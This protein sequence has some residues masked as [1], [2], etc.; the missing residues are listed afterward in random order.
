MPTVVPWAYRDRP[1]PLHFHAKA[2]GTPVRE[3]HLIHVGLSVSRTARHR[4]DTGAA[5][6]RGA[7]HSGQPVRA[8]ERDLRT[9]APRHR[10]DSVQT[11]RDCLVPQLADSLVVPT[12]ARR[13]QARHRTSPRRR[14]PRRSGSDL[15]FFATRDRLAAIVG[16]TPAPHDS[17]KK[18]GNLHRPRVN[19]L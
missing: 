4:H 18:S 9:L 12:P 17:D 10:C 14:V 19:V 15:T 7:C 8:P 13:T 1:G 2:D 11:G 3:P 5:L 6:R 16:L